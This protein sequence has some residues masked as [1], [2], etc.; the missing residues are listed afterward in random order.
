MH[1]N[2]QIATEKK[3]R[4][5][6]RAVLIKRL[7]ISSPDRQA[8]WSL[9][10]ETDHVELWHVSVPLRGSWCSKRMVDALQF[11][12]GC[13]GDEVTRTIDGKEY[14]IGDGDDW[15]AIQ[16]DNGEITIWVRHFKR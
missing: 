11:F 3:L 16:I 9:I 6:F 15:S 1:A 5:A 12:S 8:N 2:K 10:E 4:D 13:E 14:V 7:G